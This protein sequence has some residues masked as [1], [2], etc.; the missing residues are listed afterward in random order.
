MIYVIYMCMYN[1]TCMLGLC[2][3]PHNA[4]ITIAINYNNYI[5]YVYVITRLRVL[6]QIYKHQAQGP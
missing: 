2:D 4:N 3:K 5:L 1:C 6:Y